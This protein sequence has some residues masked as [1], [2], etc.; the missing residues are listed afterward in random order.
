MDRGLGGS[1]L[2]IPGL[3]LS[4][5]TSDGILPDWLRRN[6][7]GGPGSRI[8]WEVNAAHARPSE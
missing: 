3:S 8:P 6:T 5:R 2:E 1:G 7:S 4:K